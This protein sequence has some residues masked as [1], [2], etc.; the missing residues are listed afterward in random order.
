M[1]LIQ[2][3]FQLTDGY[4][5]VD[6]AS[7]RFR[8]LTGEWRVLRGARVRVGRC[9]Y[10]SCGENLELV[11]SPNKLMRIVKCVVSGGMLLQLTGCMNT[12]TF[13]DIVQTV[14]LGITAAGGYAILQNI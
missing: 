7:A 6:F 5:C 13:L 8:V 1:W 3:D 9:S 4:C 14:F 11:M 12:P 10:R 2:E